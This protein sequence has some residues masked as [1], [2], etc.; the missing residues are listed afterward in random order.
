VS[1]LDALL[2]IND[3]EEIGAGVAVDNRRSHSDYYLDVNG[4]DWT[5]PLDALI[6]VNA[7]GENLQPL[8][9]AATYLRSDPDGNGVVALPQVTVTG[10][11]ARSE[12]ADRS[13]SVKSR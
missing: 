10:R 2:V 3:L 6:V 7:I 1:P 13:G 8:A 9:I 12:R 11:T 4:D 5:S